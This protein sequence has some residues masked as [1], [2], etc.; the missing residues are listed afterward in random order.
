MFKSLVIKYDKN[1]PRINPN[2]IPIAPSIVLSFNIIFFLCD[3]S[4]PIDESTPSSLIL[5]EYVILNDVYI[6]IIA[7]I[8]INN[9]KNI[10]ITTIFFVKVL[11]SPITPA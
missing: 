9:I 8:V 10:A 11:F 6:I 3:L 7:E 1:M 5:S 2:I 4:I